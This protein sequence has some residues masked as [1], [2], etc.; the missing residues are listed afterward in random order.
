MLHL[1]AAS[2]LPED[3]PLNYIRADGHVEYVAGQDDFGARLGA[4]HSQHG[5]RAIGLWQ[6][7]GVQL[8]KKY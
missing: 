7:R 8:R 5:Q 1:L 2:E 4:V 3:D 6:W